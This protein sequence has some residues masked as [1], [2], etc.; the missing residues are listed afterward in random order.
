[1]CKIVKYEIMLHF[2]LTWCEVVFSF[3]YNIHDST[4]IIFIVSIS[5][6]EEHDVSCEI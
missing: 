1:M 3:K 6:G 2:T 5:D 4:I